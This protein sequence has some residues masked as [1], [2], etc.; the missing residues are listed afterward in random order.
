MLKYKLIAYNRI[1]PIIKNYLNHTIFTGIAIRK[2]YFV[3]NTKP[4]QEYSDY[5]VTIFQDQWDEYQSP[6]KLTAR[7][8]HITH[9]KTKCSAY[10]IVNSDI[11]VQDI[12]KDDFKYEQPDFS[13]SASTREKCTDDIIKVIN[14]Q[15]EI[16]VNRMSNALLNKHKMKREDN[17]PKHKYMIKYDD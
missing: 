4:N 2:G 3:L 7:L 14:K 15:F 1:L 11:Q 13:H 6:S 5:H 10:Y 17:K 16:V 12:P 9:E 8:F